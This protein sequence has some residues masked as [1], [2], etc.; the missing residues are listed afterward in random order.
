MQLTN[1]RGQ[2]SQGNM[3][4]GTADRA[5]ALFNKTYNTDIHV[6]QVMSNTPLNMEVGT[7]WLGSLVQKYGNTPQGIAQALYEYNPDHQYVTKVM[8]MMQGENAHIQS[9]VQ[10]TAQAVQVSQAPQQSAI[11]QPA[12]PQPLA[13]AA[14]QQL[15]GEAGSVYAARLERFNQAQRAA[16]IETAQIAAK[17]TTQQGQL[18]NKVALGVSPQGDIQVQSNLAEPEATAKG[19]KLFSDPGPESQ[20]AVKARQS[21]ATIDDLYTLLRSMSKEEEQLGALPRLMKTIGSGVHIPGFGTVGASAA[22]QALLTPNQRKMY[23]LGESLVASLPGIYGGDINTVTSMLTSAFTTK[24]A[25]MD[26]LGTIRQ[27]IL[28]RAKAT[29]GQIEQ[30]STQPGGQ[31]VKTENTLAAIRKRLQITR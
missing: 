15:P 10:Q 13:T 27:D 16:G 4:P 29:F 9:S 5:V 22:G 21:L 20:F 2:D 12:T 1:D 17:Q 26:A 6:D 28:Q 23:S 25:V 11:V 18:T 24:S 3:L 19:M 7:F 30:P 8:T 14:P 31:A